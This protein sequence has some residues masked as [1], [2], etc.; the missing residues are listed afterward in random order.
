MNLEQLR[1]MLVAIT[2]ALAAIETK[3]TTEN[4]RLPTIEEAREIAKLNDEYSQVQG[5]INTIKLKESV[6]GA[7]NASAGRI[8]TNAQGVGVGVNQAQLDP[9][10]GWK[11][12]GEFARCVRGAAL[13]QGVDPRLMKPAWL[14]QAA[15]TTFANEASGPDGGYLVPPAM[16]SAI[17]E[18]LFDGNDLINQLEIEPTQSNFVQLNADE[19]TPWGSTGIT[20]QWAGEAAT[21]TAT[22]KPALQKRNVELHKI[23]ALVAASDELLEDAPLMVNRLTRGAARAIQWATSDAVMWGDGVAKPKGFMQSSALVTISKESGQAAATLNSNNIVKMLSRFWM[24]GL[25]SPQ[26]IANTD[27]L[28]QLAGMTLGQNGLFFLPQKGLLDGVPGTLLG[29]PIRFSEH[30]KSL[31]TSGDITLADMPAGYYAAQKSGGI[32]YDTSIHLW[33][34]SGL[35]AFRW[36]WRLGGQTFLS[37]AVSPKNGSATK[38][39]F[40]TIEDRA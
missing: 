26:W 17:W 30:A 15:P 20:A 16:S 40:V 11:G 7:L 10:G 18:L 9:L 3:R 22:G 21:L 32:K 2:T 23:F 29:L 24:M 4:N 14:S 34:D 37:A 1:A 28:P 36:T 12:I 39:H 19:T 31:G 35:Q 27:V 25:R 13:N 8:T 6:A 38:S 5:A 33:F